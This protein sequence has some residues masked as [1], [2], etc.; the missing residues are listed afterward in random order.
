[1]LLLHTGEAVHIYIC[2]CDDLFISDLNNDLSVFTSHL[3]MCTVYVNVA[4]ASC[5]CSF[6][7]PGHS[8]QDRAASHGMR[9]AVLRP[10]HLPSSASHPDLTTTYSQMLSSAGEPATVWTMCCVSWSQAQHSTSR[11]GTRCSH[12]S[13]IVQ[14]LLASGHWGL[15]RH[16]GPVL[17]STH[18]PGP[19]G[20]QAVLGRGRCA[21]GRAGEWSEEMWP[22]IRLWAPNRSQSVW[23][24]TLH[25]AVAGNTKDEGLQ[26][27][28]FILLSWKRLHSQSGQAAAGLGC[29]HIPAMAEVAPASCGTTLPGQPLL[30]DEFWKRLVQG[31]SASP[32]LCRGS[33]P[34]SAHFSPE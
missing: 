21:E 34:S 24:G 20:P 28:A 26:V 6:P 12:G 17:H 29:L 16:S 22:L 8:S 1:M 14:C 32:G 3:Q 30:R 18:L 2:K 25:K 5:V 31:M 7:T 33:T 19:L 23:S 15:R 4:L 11:H 9:T 27:V 13:S 10:S